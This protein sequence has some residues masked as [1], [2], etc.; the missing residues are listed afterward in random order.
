MAL[1]RLLLPLALLLLTA[2][3][4][5]ASASRVASAKLVSCD[6]E[7]RTVAFEGTMRGVPG[8]ARLQMRFTLQV[9]DGGWERVAAPTFDQW[10]SAAPGKT[11]YVYAKQVEDLVPGAYRVL[12]RFRWRDAAGAVLRTA[13]RRSK[14]CVVPDER[15]NL[16]PVKIRQQQGPAEG[17]TRYTVVV[18]NRG[19]SPAGAFTVGFSVDGV[20]LPDRRIPGL[21]PTERAT[22]A[23]VGPACDHDDDVLVASVDR[24][25]LVDEADEADDTLSAAC[26]D[27]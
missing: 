5:S 25:G 7:A 6:P 17:T 19:L 22:V 2:A 23:F 27:V 13:K 8:A 15:P 16:A 10:A 4:A 21:A 26:E 9:A 3:P 12:V 14:T 18:V 20:A 1:R 11:G 24:E